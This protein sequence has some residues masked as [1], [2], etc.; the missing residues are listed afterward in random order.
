M[1]LTLAQDAMQVLV[2]E[3]S[4][5]LPLFTPSLTAG[6]RD[7]LQRN[8]QDVCTLYKTAYILWSVMMS[9]LRSMRNSLNGFLGGRL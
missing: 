4:V 1:Q 3:Y 2:Y 9:S 5:I 6:K 7:T 8:Q